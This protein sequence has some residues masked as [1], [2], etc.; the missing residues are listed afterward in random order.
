VASISNLSYELAEE[1]GYTRYDDNFDPVRKKLEE[2]GNK[3]IWTKKNH[4]DKP[5]LFHVCDGPRHYLQGG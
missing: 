4:A 2:F 5:Y 3:C 1:L